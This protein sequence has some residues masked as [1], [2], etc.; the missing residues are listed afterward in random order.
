LDFDT[1]SDETTELV[2]LEANINTYHTNKT[3]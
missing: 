2:V 1:S 3:A